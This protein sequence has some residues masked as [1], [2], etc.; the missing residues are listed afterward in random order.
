MEYAG[1]R[2]CPLF[3][4]CVIEGRAVSEDITCSSL[5]KSWIT[6]SME[7]LSFIAPYCQLLTESFCSYRKDVVRR[8]DTYF[9]SSPLT[10]TD[11]TLRQACRLSFFHR[12]FYP[13]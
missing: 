1:A 4:S 10:G 9:A 3:R 8:P 6:L 7:Q 13:N 2:V 5:E 12:P 11:H